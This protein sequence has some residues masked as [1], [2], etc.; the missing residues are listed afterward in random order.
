MNFS[1][2]A[3]DMGKQMAEMVEYIL[4]LNISPED[5]RLRLVRAF[6]IVGNEFYSKMF[7]DN[8][9]LFDSLAIKSAGYTDPEGQVERLASKLVQ[10]YNLGRPND[11][12]VKEFFDS[13]LGDA[14]HEAFENGRMMERVPTLTR[15]LVGETCEWCRSRVGTFTNP[16]GEMFTRHDN[17]D[18]LFI[19]KGYNSR[20]GVL[21]NYR[22]ARK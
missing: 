7:V 4:S 9:E 17:C 16:D 2:V 6:G 3:T 18:C 13:V 19:V 10:N 20:N 14:Q 22:K 11:A 21:T 15:Q 12:I 8:S 5:K 1:D